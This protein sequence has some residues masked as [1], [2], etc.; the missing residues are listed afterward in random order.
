MINTL[1]YNK[2]TL[3]NYLTNENT[4]NF[5]FIDKSQPYLLNDAIFDTSAK[6]ITVLSNMKTGSG[7]YVIRVNGKKESK[8]EN[9]QFV[10]KYTPMIG[11][12]H[13]IKSKNECLIYKYIRNLIKDDIC[14]F[15][16]Y[17]FICEFIDN[18]DIDQIDPILF[19]I[20][21]PKDNS[22]KINI[23][24]VVILSTNNNNDTNSLTL[25]KLL[26]KQEFEYENLLIILFQIM[27]TLKCFQQIGLKHNDLHFGNIIIEQRKNPIVIDKDNNTINKYIIGDK[28]YNIPNVNYTV[29]IF[30]F[31]LSEKFNR[32]NLK[33]E[34]QD[35]TE[36]KSIDYS[37]SYSNTY[38]NNE[39][40]IMFDLLKVIDRFINIKNIAKSKKLCINDEP[41]D[42]LLN[43]F[44]NE[45]DVIDK[46]TELYNNKTNTINFINGIMKYIL[47]NIKTKIEP[48][49]NQ[50]LINYYFLDNKLYPFD[51][52]GNYG[53]YDKKNYQG[54]KTIDEILDIIYAAITN[55]YDGNFPNPTLLHTFNLNNLFTSKPRPTKSRSRGRGESSPES[56]SPESKTRTSVQNLV[57]NRRISSI[58]LRGG[59]YNKYIK[60]KTKKIKDKKI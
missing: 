43:S 29:K 1:A 15:L 51:N 24:Q 17:G 53:N 48:N 46:I 8:Y 59:A 54:I 28:E 9:K 34:Y 49:T 45:Q 33:N 25:E 20:I 22:G 35:I 38:L 42:I 31:D 55:M 11:E 19:N 56:S 44:F 12:I 3:T 2:N 57:T 37:K 26:L 14:P 60:N 32:D 41:F 50:S 39:D 21:N 36:F 16:Y 40:N 4:P 10:V 13:K 23:T 47:T 7:T 27:Y 18:K 52:Y 5:T 6:N 58:N 30:D